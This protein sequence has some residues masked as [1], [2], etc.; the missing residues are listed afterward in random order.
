M[1]DKTHLLILI[2]A[3]KECS[4]K[5]YVICTNHI[6]L[7][8]SEQVLL[9]IQEKPLGGKRKVSYLLFLL[10]FFFFLQGSRQL[11]PRIYCSHVA[12]CTTL[13][14]QTLTT[15]RLPKRSWQSE[16]EL[17]L[18]IIFRRSNFH[19]QSSPQRSQQLKVEL[20]GREMAD[21]FCLKFPTST[22]HS[23]IFYMT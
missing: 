6:V 19:H 22:Q 8:S 16:V 9:K 12:Y 17:N 14:V 5:N 15:S 2:V 23:G 21:E 1:T 18:I 11:M 7:N 3:I 20:C 4:F 10:F 13:D